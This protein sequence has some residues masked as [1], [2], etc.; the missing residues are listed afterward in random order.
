MAYE[1]IITEKPQAAKKIA[2]SLADT[3]ATKLSENKVP[4]YKLTHKGKEIV[5]AS[6]VGH[7]YTVAEKEKGK[8]QYPIFDVAWVPS[9]KVSK[10]SAF[11]SKYATVLRKLSKGASEFTVACD[12]D[13]EG[14]VIGY[15]VIKHISK[16]KDARR[17][18]FSTLT[19]QELVDAYENAQ[20][21]LEWGQVN[22]GVTRHELDWYYG[23]NL[24]RALTLAVKSTG[25]FKI[26]SSGR[27]QGPAL[28]IIVDKEKEIL[29]FVPEPYWQI[30]LKG[31]A[32][33][34]PILAWHRQD[35]FTDHGLAQQS[36]EKAKG[37][38]G[39]VTGTEKKQ[40]RQA[41][42]T[43]FDLTTLQ[44]EAYRCLGYQ[45][46]KTLEYAQE[47][48]IAGLISYPRTSSQKLP[49]KIGYE[50]ILGQLSKQSFYAE[51]CAK[52]L[53]KPG[54]K[55]NEGSKTD[56][57]HPAIY[58]TGNITGIEGQKARVYD[59][60]VR[61][62]LATFGD[63]AVR[64]TATISI[65]VN[66]EPFVAKGTRTVEPGW[67]LFYGQH[68]KLQEETV[69]P[70]TDGDVVNVEELNLL[71]KMTQP[72]KRYT[73]ASIIRELEKR[74]L[75]TKATRAQIVD[76]LYDRGY[77]NEKSIQA[78]ALGIRTCETL[79]KYSPMI[80]DEELTRHFEEEMD[81]IFDSKIK[82]EDVLS[83]ARDK[84]TSILGQFKE[85]QSEVGK[86]L[87]SALTETR[88]TM[89]SVGQC[90]ECKE[91]TLAVRKGKY[92]SFI[93]CSRYPECKKTIK[94]PGGRVKVTKDVCKDCGYP[95]VV[96]SSGK[97][98]QK[99]CI[100][101]DCP[102]KSSPEIEK[103]TAAI[104]N[105]H[106]EKKCPKC[107]KP[108]KLRQSIYGKFLGCSGFPKCRHTEKLQNGN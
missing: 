51:L 13:I 8:W 18:K 14:E 92:G 77:V 2:E 103:E 30:E 86:E 9:S 90:P 88:D 54:L 39:K 25:M 83:E 63:P 62:F 108:L 32:K 61:R 65:D 75:G 20:A 52:L 40:F 101:N 80:L 59:L 42:P 19:K 47:L 43:P 34:E 46:K 5:V 60:I 21:H 99:V 6:A 33:D 38:D 28:K 105:G 84:L 4:Y 29:A 23:I 17:M 1:L 11:T 76:N 15:N 70:V 58:P 68:V 44:T 48:Y 69:P 102:S 49:P 82:P 45:P 74:N 22:A 71:D 53:A 50:K 97:K 79:E 24:S 100:N 87:A 104:E 64:E 3:K 37:H 81:Q 72:P 85:K 35:K 91:G 96:I 27:V 16:Q 36:Y 94:L 12:F 10:T 98:P 41:P 107:G 56:P 55:P 78:T 95:T 89:T 7:L 93:A 106:V 26:L 31:K 67:H 66:S 57:A 73:P